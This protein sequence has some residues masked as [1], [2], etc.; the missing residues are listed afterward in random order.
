MS[1]DIRNYVFKG[2]PLSEFTA[3]LSKHPR[4]THAHLTSEDNAKNFL[5]VDESLVASLQETQNSVH[6]EVDGSSID[7][8]QISAAVARE[9]RS[10]S[11]EGPKALLFLTI[12]RACGIALSD[13]LAAKKESDPN[14]Q[15]EINSPFNLSGVRGF[16]LVEMQ[17][18][19]LPM[20][21]I[22]IPYELKGLVYIASQRENWNFIGDPKIDPETYE[23]A[24]P[25]L[26]LDLEKNIKWA[27]N[28]T[29]SSG[30]DTWR[31][32]YCAMLINLFIKPGEEYV[33]EDDCW[34]HDVGVCSTRHGDV[35]NY[36]GMEENEMYLIVTGPE[37]VCYDEDGWSD[38]EEETPTAY[39]KVKELLFGG[40]DYPTEKYNPKFGG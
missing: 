19:T 36:G 28:S 33:E 11:F 15:V 31:E 14:L 20:G 10:L 8:S 7:V 12:L 1:Y 9:Q 26:T 23:T 2:V 39:R 25:A 5:L 21:L 3:N 16:P 34:T 29:T 18:D 27:Q 30:Y 4:G 32:A 17:G 6:Y 22:E 35:C 13:L 40:P 37:M 24:E 38:P